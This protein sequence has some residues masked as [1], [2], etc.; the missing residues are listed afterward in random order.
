M[1]AV[2]K[3]QKG[4]I[5]LGLRGCLYESELARVPEL[6]RFPETILSRV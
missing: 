6:A 4:A 1:S 3:V 2:E 5:P